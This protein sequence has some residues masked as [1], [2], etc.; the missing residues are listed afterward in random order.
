MDMSFMLDNTIPEKKVDVDAFINRMSKDEL[1]FIL[2]C[3]KYLM[4]LGLIKNKVQFSH[5]YLGKSKDYVSMLQT[6][7]GTPSINC[8]Q[9]LV[10]AMEETNLLYE[11]KNH[12]I[13][14]N[15][16]HLIEEGINFITRR[17]LKMYDGK[18]LI[19]VS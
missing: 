14:N 13:E 5:Q 8:L 9:N 12:T 16:N 2:K 18:K 15:L 3:C 6:T 7:S 10:K 17:L 11:G 19:L 4:V 1:S